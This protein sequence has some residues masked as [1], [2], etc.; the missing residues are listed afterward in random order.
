MTSAST[1]ECR[2][3]AGSRA[4]SRVRCKAIWA[5]LDEQAIQIDE[6][7]KDDDFIADVYKELSCASSLEALNRGLKD[8]KVMLENLDPIVR[9]ERDQKIQSRLTVVSKDSPLIK[10][11]RRATNVSEN[12]ISATDL[13]SL[14]LLVV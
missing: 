1:I 4:R 3:K 14:Q 2:T 9:A 5:V 12:L 7:M 6:N 8:Q 10:P 13:Q 11:V